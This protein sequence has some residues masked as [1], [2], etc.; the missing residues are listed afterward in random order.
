MPDLNDDLLHLKHR[1]EQSMYRIL[2]R[3]ADEDQDR[4]WMME[5]ISDDRLK[6]LLPHLSI[7]SLHVLDVI[8]THGSIKGVDIAREMGMTKGAVSK[9][10]RKLLDQGLIQKTQLPDNLKEIYFSV[11]PLGTELAEM[12]QVF[13]QAQE[14]RGLELFKSYDM[15]SL[16]IVADFLEKL[17]GLVSEPP[18]PEE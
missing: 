18:H 13:H 7:S 6:K 5:R 3:E 14:H 17:A 15:V 16:E 4:L 2:I 9:I 12:H 11:T 10:T 1:I 8:F